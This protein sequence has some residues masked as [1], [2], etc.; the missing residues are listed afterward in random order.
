MLISYINGD[1]L[2]AV[3][4]ISPIRTESKQKQETLKQ[5]TRKI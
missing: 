1:L 5:T 3:I 4:R 2:L